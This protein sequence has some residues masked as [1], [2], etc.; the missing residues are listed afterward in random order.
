MGVARELTRRLVDPT[1][2]GSIS[3]R[4]RARRWARFTETFPGLSGMRV[5]DL[6]GR[7]AF[8]TD[9]PVTPTAV[10]VVNLERL[11]SRGPI[12]AIRGDACNLP[13]ELAGEAFD[14]VVSNSLMEHVGGHAQRQRLA[15]NIHASAEYHWVQT[16]YRYF[17]L[18]PHWVFPG[19]QF[20]P[21]ATRVYV[22][23]RWPLGHRHSTDDAVATSAVHEVDLIGMRQMR[24]YFPDS[25]IWAE[26]F[27]GLPKSLVAMRS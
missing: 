18:E 9:A 4:A 15:D 3:A 17:P 13:H 20:L 23:K 14:L 1:N 25:N 19:M 21:F 7:P 5:L 11:A 2:P 26:R 16:P 6:G 8:W 22:A 10:V 12:T 27:A 24:S